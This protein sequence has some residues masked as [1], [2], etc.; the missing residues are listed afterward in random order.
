LLY[1]IDQRDIWDTSYVHTDLT[2]RRSRFTKEVLLVHGSALLEVAAAALIT[3][4]ISEPVGE[5]T[6]YSCGV[7]RYNVCDVF[8][9][10]SLS[11]FLQEV[12]IRVYLNSG[13]FILA[14]YRS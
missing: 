7:T 9:I 1:F 6:L 10:Q 14:Q 2:A 13:S 11:C 12:G 3:L 4:L 8:L 5:L